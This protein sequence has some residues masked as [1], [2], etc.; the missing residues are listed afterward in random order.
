M[1]ITVLASQTV[2]VT[3]ETPAGPITLTVA[4]LGKPMRAERQLDTS[5]YG[6]YG[7]AYRMILRYVERWDLTEHGKPLPVTADVLDRLPFQIVDAIAAAVHG[8]IFPKPKNDDSSA[9]G[10][11]P[12]ESSD[13]P[14]TGT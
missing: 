10:S 11:S 1:D 14:L 13:E 2:E 12:E 5:A 7:P 9:N 8:V 4:K 3:A 6:D